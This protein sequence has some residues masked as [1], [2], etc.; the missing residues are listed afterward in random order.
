MIGTADFISHRITGFAR[1]AAEQGM[2]GSINVPLVSHVRGN[3]WMG[4]C[5][6]GVSLP[7][8]FLHVISLYDTERYTCGPDTERVYYKMHD[9]NDLPNEV[10]LYEIAAEVNLKVT[11]GKTLV[12]CQAGLN[13]SGLVT[14]LALILEGMEPSAAISLLRERRS[15]VVLCNKTFYDWLLRQDPEVVALHL[16]YCGGA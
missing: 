9:S 14:A 11:L 7:E 5:R 3:L 15:Q 6:H 10:R 16:A 2:D 12:H 8:D 4:G 1:M 13:R